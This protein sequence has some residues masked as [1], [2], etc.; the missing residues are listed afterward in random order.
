MSKHPGVRLGGCFEIRPTEDIGVPDRLSE[1]YA[2]PASKE[3]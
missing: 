2:Q 1:K 3:K